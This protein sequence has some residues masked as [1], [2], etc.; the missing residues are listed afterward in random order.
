M[1]AYRA[2]TLLRR[3]P[4]FPLCLHSF[5]SL[6]PSLGEF[7]AEHYDN[8]AGGLISRAATI[9]IYL[10]DTPQGGGTYFPRS[11]G[12]PQPGSSG[13][14]PLP[15]A[16][17]L[18]EALAALTQQLHGRSCSGGGRPGLRVLP[19]QGRAVIFWSRLPD[20]GEDLSSLHSAEPVREGIKWIATRWFKEVD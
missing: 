5:P 16:R 9:I 7:Y 11:T 2:L 12:L 20:G 10:E 14:L 19:T 3:I 18:P 6:C 17:S 1:F 15:L 4:S 13:A 8:K